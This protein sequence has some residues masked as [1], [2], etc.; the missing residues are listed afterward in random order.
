[1]LISKF[2][3]MTDISIILDFGISSRHKLTNQNY[4]QFRNYHIWKKWLFQ[5][6]N[7]MD[8]CGT[9]KGMSKQVKYCYQNSEKQVNLWMVIFRMF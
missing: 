9:I 8:Y 4:H 7:L 6:Y 5:K 2:G 3:D 1:M